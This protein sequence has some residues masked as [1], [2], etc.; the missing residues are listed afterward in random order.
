MG[1]LLD[2]FENKSHILMTIFMS[3]QA[4][5]FTAFIILFFMHNDDKDIRYKIYVCGTMGLFF[6]FMVHFAYHSVKIFL[7]YI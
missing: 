2:F 1:K 4:F 7:I 5:L 3:L 6:I